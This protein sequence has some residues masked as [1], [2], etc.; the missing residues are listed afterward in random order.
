M[1]IKNMYIHAG[2]VIIMLE[3]PPQANREPI[4]TDMSATHGLLT[5][6]AMS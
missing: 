5:F 3:K 2:F 6:Q 1:G 4:A